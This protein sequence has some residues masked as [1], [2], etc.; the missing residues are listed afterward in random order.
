M[1]REV[2]QVELRGGHSQEAEQKVEG[3]DK[4]A[5]EPSKRPKNNIHIQKTTSKNIGNKT[6]P[7]IGYLASFK[8]LIALKIKRYA[9]IIKQNIRIEIY[10]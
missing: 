5:L 1:D 9:A 6:N 4:S 2:E 3:H 7:S 10:I 8:G